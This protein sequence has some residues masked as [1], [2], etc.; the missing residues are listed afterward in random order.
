[1]I[2]YKNATTMGK[3][4][5]RITDLRLRYYVDGAGV[6]RTYWGGS[7]VEWHKVAERDARLKI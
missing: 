2:D 3:I 6:V 7:W 1:M 5:K 4:M